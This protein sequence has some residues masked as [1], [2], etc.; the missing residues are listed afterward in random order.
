MSASRGLMSSPSKRGFTL[1]E[2]LVVIAIIGVLVALLLPAVQAAREAARVATCKNRLRQLGLALLNYHD[3][4]KEFPVGVSGGGA[5]PRSRCIDDGHGWGVALL[6]YLEQQPLYD[7]IQPD[8]EPCPFRTAHGNTRQIIQG[9]DTM[10][11]VFRCPSSELGPHAEPIF[12]GLL[13]YATSDYKASTGLG[14]S[15]LFYKTYDGER[16]GYAR[17]RIADVT[18]GL[19]NTIAFGESAYY[20]G[21]RNWPIWLGAPGTDEATLFKTDARAPI[22]CTISPKTISNF[23]SAIDDDCAFSWHNGGAHFS[24][25]DGSVHWLVEEID[26]QTY[27]DMGTKNDGRVLG[28]Y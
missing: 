9:G 20:E 23:S 15:G 3:V 19:S 18:D 27:W 13:G 11:E 14:D 7:L 21:I 24:F 5:G 26:P 10:L 25:A 6:P 17:V 1:V 8:F 2:L 4:R 16:S 12:A 28:D 22:N